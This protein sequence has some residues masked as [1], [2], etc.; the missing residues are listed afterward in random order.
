[1][2][3]CWHQIKKKKCNKILLQLFKLNLPCVT[4]GKNLRL[5]KN[6]MRNS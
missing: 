2:Y 4:L 1:M 5:K 6:W 3:M